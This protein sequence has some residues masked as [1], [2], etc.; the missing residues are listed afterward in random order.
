MIPRENKTLCVR[1]L[2][3]LGPTYALHDALRNFDCMTSNRTMNS[4]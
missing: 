1:T 2:V 4:K 3:Y